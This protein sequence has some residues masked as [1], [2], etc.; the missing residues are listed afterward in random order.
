MHV[1]GDWIVP[2][3]AGEPW[4]RGPAALPLDRARLRQAAAAGCSPFHNAARLA[5]GVLVAGRVLVRLPRRARLAAGR[6]AARGRRAPLLLLLGSIGLMVH[7]H[8][9]LPELA[10]LAAAVRARSPCCRTRSAGRCSPALAF[11][12]ALGLAVPR[13]RAGSRRRRS[14]A[15]VAGA[16]AACP[17]WRTARALPFL[18][19]R[20]ARGRALVAAA[21]R[22]RSRSARP[23]SLA[24]VVV[25]R[26]AAARRLLGQPALLPRHRRAGSPGPRGRSRSGRCGRCAAHWREPR[27]FVPARRVAARR[28]PAFA[29]CGPPQDV[30]LHRAAARRSR[31]SARRASRSCAAARP[32][33]ST[34]SACMTFG[35]FAALVWLG[36]VAML[37][38]VPP[39]SPATSP[40]P[41]RASRRSSAAAR[42]CVALAL[43][44]GWLYLVFFTARSPMRGVTRWAAG[45]ALLWGSFADAVDA[46]G[47]LPEELPQRRAAAA[48]EDAGGRAAASRSRASACRSARR[49]TTTP[50]SAPQ[51]FEPAQADARARCSS[52]RA[53]RSDERDGP[54]PR[55]RKLADVGRPG[56]QHRA[57]PPL[58]AAEQM[59]RLNTTPPTECPA[60]A[61]LARARRELARGAA[62]RPVRAATPRARR[63]S[64]PTRRACA[65]LFAPAPRRAD[66]APARAARRRARPAG[67]RDALFAGEPINTTEERAAL[68]HGAARGRRGA[69]EVHA[70]LERMRDSGRQGP[71]RRQFAASSTSASAAPTSAR[72]CS[73]TRSA[74]PRSTCT[75]PRTS[76]RPT[77]S[78]RSPDA[79]PATTLFIVGLK[80]FTTAET[81]AN[82]ARGEGAG[83]RHGRLSSR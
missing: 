71:R 49:S 20:C 50:A 46:L 78:A 17:A 64:S 11:G 27:L 15:A 69:A 38:G 28:S 54:A 45:I 25:R 12:A 21:G 3:I 26:H 39:K 31:C 56:D 66:A 1:T 75:S 51:P 18:G 63:S 2:R 67:W 60:W 19:C 33:R 6:E 72:A 62:A 61:K 34:G 83:G 22:S 76:I 29:F 16:H 73:P 10:A 70:T 77:S 8:E 5:S 37:T 23:S 65:R 68:A 7:A 13:G 24:D 79:E 48:L 74:T 44:L 43:T 32:P 35:F 40:R 9:A 14:A 59:T 30:N 42:F 36:Y 82:A 80:T 4:L 81:L 58:S 52:C 41:R 53:A 55:W 57:L 47:R